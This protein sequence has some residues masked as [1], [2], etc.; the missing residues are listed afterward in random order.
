MVCAAVRIA[1]DARI[2]FDAVLTAKMARCGVGDRTVVMGNAPREVAEFGW[3][4]ED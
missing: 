4:A 3:R 1:A 2:L